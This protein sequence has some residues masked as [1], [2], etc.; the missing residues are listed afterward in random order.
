MTIADNKDGRFYMCVFLSSSLCAC[1]IV[2]PFPMSSALRC[3]EDLHMS[4]LVLLDFITSGK[5]SHLV[6]FFKFLRLNSRG[7]KLSWGALLDCVPFCEVENAS[8]QLANQK[9]GDLQ[10]FLDGGRLCVYRFCFTPKMLEALNVGLR[11]WS[12]H[13]NFA[14]SACLEKQHLW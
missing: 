12:R 6:I 14:G 1:S 7:R 10:G 3:S 13:R 9:T 11:E 8:Q 2:L 5:V 4:V